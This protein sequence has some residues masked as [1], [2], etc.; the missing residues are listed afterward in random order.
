MSNYATYEIENAGLNWEHLADGG[1]GHMDAALLKGEAV[2]VEVMASKEGDYD[3][4]ASTVWV[5]VK[6]G[7]QYFKKEGWY[8]SYDGSTWDGSLSE[9]RPQTKTIMVW[10]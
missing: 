8:A 1:E 2:L 7:D 10:E 9:V 3:E 6:V 5:I 4:G